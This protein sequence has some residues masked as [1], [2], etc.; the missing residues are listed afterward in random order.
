MIE[1]SVNSQPRQIDHKLDLARLLTDWGYDATKVAVA[2]N[3]DF[4]PRSHYAGFHLKPTDRV[5]V[6]SPVQG[7]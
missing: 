4:V 6:V 2:V 3:A 5:D 7:G 1:I